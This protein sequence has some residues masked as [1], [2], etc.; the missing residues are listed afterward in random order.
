M[1]LVPLFEARV[2]IHVDGRA[3]LS[4]LKTRLT[5]SKS[6]LIEVYIVRRDYP[7]EEVDGDASA[8]CKAVRC[9]DGYCAACRASSG[10]GVRRVVRRGAAARRRPHRIIA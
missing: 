10:P 2:V 6:E 8:E 9:G 7:I 1:R 5:A 3:V 4:E